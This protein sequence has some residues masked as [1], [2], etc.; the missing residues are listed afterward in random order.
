[1]VRKMTRKL[2]SKRNTLQRGIEFRRGHKIVV[3]NIE[4][5]CFDDSLTLGLGSK[6]S[7]NYCPFPDSWPGLFF[8]L[9]DPQKII[10]RNIAAG[11]SGDIFCHLAR[12][13]AASIPERSDPT[14]SD[15][16]RLRKIAALD[17]FGFEVFGQPHGQNV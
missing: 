17:A 7:G 5:L 16:D 4:K 11:R 13:P 15:A 3:S 2:V 8:S 1:M 10:R 14:A 6:K 9:D 12:R